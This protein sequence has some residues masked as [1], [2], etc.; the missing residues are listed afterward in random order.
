MAF[1]HAGITRLNI[2]R[3]RSSSRRSRPR[4]TARGANPQ[5]ATFPL[6]DAFREI[7]DS[8]R[9]APDERT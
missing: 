4:M 8:L 1:F 2:E 5:R 7:A 3:S 9:A 6:A